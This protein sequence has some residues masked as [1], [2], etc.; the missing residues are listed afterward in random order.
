MNQKERTVDR[1]IEDFFIDVS[2]KFNLDSGDIRPEQRV[3]IDDFNDLILKYIEQNKENKNMNNVTNKIINKIMHKIQDKG[4]DDIDELYD[5]INIIIYN[6]GITDYDI[7]DI[8]EE[9]KEFNLFASA[10]ANETVGAFTSMELLHDIAYE[11]LKEKVITRFVNNKENK[12]E[13]KKDAKKRIINIISENHNITQKKL[14]DVIE[15][16]EEDQIKFQHVLSDFM[17]DSYDILFD[18]NSKREAAIELIGGTDEL[19][20]LPSWLNKDKVNFIGIYEDMKYRSQDYF[21]EN[22]D[23]GIVIV[24]Y[25]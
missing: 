4:I 17:Y 23:K 19:Y 5:N 11:I 3:V 22:F 16:M 25:F 18:V 14:E 10:I 1:M 9:N 2:Q 20:R 24:F 6:L 15:I 13:L 7:L 8:I 12:D 21:I